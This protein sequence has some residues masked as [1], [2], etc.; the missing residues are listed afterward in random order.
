MSFFGYLNEPHAPLRGKI[1]MKMIFWDE[2][3]YIYRYHPEERK[4][5]CYA[6]TNL[7]NEKEN[8]S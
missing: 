6:Q 1:P 4:Y 7:P 3:G 5:N 2:K 8:R